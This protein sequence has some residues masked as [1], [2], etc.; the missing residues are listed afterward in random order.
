MHIVRQEVSFKKMCVKGT[1]FS[2]YVKD[3][4]NL[5][6]YGKKQHKKKCNKIF[7]KAKN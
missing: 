2:F 4:P 6:R 3:C 1:K 5:E 7:C